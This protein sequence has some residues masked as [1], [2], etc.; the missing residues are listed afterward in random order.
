MTI[1]YA[2]YLSFKAVRNA[3]KNQFKKAKKIHTERWQGMDISNHP[4]GQMVEILNAHIHVPQVPRTIELLANDLVRAV[5]LPWAE[6]HFAERVCGMPINPGKEWANWPDGGSAAR[7]LDAN[8]QFNHNYMERYWPRHA[9]QTPDG[10]Y[11]S[12]TE[13]RPWRDA[14]IGI[15]HEYGDLDSLVRLLRKEPDT[16][17][18]YLPIF[19]PEDTGIGDG[20]RKPCTLGYQFI[21]RDGKLHVYY[22]MRS[23]DFYR[24]WGDDVYLTIRLAQWI[25][26]QLQDHPIWA[27]ITVG[28][29]TMHCTSLHM[30]IND[31]YLMEKENA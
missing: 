20:G 2:N 22:P 23:C 21:L 18:A 1:F 3:L 16:R 17:Q 11:A 10:T 29:Y 12:R 15:R 5:N 31:Y 25:L 14:H 19:F 8:G 24:H 9:G 13:A 4:A 6:D 30:F 27:G 28:S 7:F 26:E